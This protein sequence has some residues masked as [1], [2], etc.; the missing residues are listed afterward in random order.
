MSGD[1]SLT[2]LITAL[3]S[4]ITAEAFWGNIAPFGTF[5]A[6]MVVFAFGYRVIRKVISGAGRGKA[7]I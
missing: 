6:T 3:T 7:K 5:L 2:S 1:N 4:N